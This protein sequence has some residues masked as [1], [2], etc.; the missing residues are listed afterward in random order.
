MRLCVTCA[1]LGL[2][3]L[4][5]LDSSGGKTKLPP[6]VCCP[7]KKPLCA[8]VLF[9]LTAFGRAQISQNT[10]DV[11]FS[12]GVIS[13]FCASWVKLKLSFVVKRSQTKP[14]SLMQMQPG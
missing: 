14:S 1:L 4:T 6:L 10:S 3:L 2:L 8:C 11:V 12:R 13:T 9:N 5:L 7:V